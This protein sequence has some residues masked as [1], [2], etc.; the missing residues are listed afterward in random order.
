MPWQEQSAMSL[1]REFVQA[2]EQGQLSF[3]EACQ[4]FQISRRTGYKWWERYL[5]E[6]EAGLADRSRRPHTSP[7]QTAAEREA[8]VLA[9]RDAHP[10]WGGR[11]LRAVLAR[12]VASAVPSA[13]TITEILRR[14]GR[15]DP[16]EAAQHTPWHRFEHAQPNDLWQLDFK[17][18][19]PLG[20]G[21]CHPLSVLDDHSRYTVGLVACADEQDATV[22]AALTQLF[23][24]YGL[25]RAILTDNGPPWGNPEPLTQPLTALSIWLLRLGIAVHHG[26]AHHPQ[27]QGKVERFHRT[28]KAELLQAERYPEL[29]TAQTAFDAWRDLYNYHRPH[30]ALDLAVP[31]HRYQWSPRSFPATLPPIDYP[32]HDIVRRVYAGGQISYRGHLYY[33]SQ[34]LGGYPVALRPT[35]TDGLLTVAFMHYR[36]GE[37]DLHN[38]R[39]TMLYGRSVEV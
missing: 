3:T 17:G 31:A 14:H 25:P 2:I 30:E 24:C 19:I 26:R 37:L 7:Q 28:L 34:T 35:T 15:L 16:A 33:I 13:S 11:K 8:R 9:L 1:R 20:T 6:G 32:D 27:T 10:R 22:R 29:A 5:A 12:E 18:Y 21:W 36:M 39:F 4:R 38:H 23:R